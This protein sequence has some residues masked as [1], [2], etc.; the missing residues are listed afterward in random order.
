MNET[1]QGKVSQGTVGEVEVGKGLGH[2]F[3]G[4]KIGNLAS[5]KKKIHPSHMNTQKK[6]LVQCFFLFVLDP[7]Y[8][9]QQKNEFNIYLFLHFLFFSFV[10]FNLLINLVRIFSSK[11]VGK[12]RFFFVLLNFH[13]TRKS[14][15]YS[16]SPSLLCCW[17]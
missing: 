1:P 14:R 10:F 4:E 3:P 12:V 16:S 11:R 2:V 17:R 7:N 13:M 5:W 8:K 9:K 6:H 15:C